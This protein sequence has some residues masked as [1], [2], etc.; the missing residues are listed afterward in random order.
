MKLTS[1]FFVYEVASVLHPLETPQTSVGVQQ[2]IMDIV[3]SLK[4]GEKISM[5]ELGKALAEVNSK[6]ELVPVVRSLV[7]EVLIL[8]EVSLKDPLTNLDNRR[9]LDEKLPAMM[10]RLERQ[11]PPGKMA[12]FMIDVDHFKKVNDTLGHPMG[13]IALYKIAQLLKGGVRDYDIVARY[14]GEE[15]VVA[16]ETDEENAVKVAETLRMAV[17]KNLKKLMKENCKN[18]EQEKLV[19]SMAGTISIGISFYNAEK[20]VRISYSDLIAE[21][22]HL[23]YKAKRT[24]NIWMA[25]EPDEEVEA[26]EK[27]A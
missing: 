20:G 8:Q 23:L 21:A 2:T 6:E 16:V 4:R 27:T 18:K 1:G 5:D 25:Y 17:E 3:D 22:D 15:F 12:V 13:D 7:N 24:R 9:A 14:G 19:D 26:G 11:K 10:S